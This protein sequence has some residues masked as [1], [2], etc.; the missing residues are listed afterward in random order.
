MIIIIALVPIA[1]DEEDKKNI[2]S[3][4]T[5]HLASTFDA[6]ITI[7]TDPP[8]LNSSTASFNELRNNQLNSDKLLR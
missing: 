7:L 6:S 5:G 1:L 3:P 2:F 8:H 4:L